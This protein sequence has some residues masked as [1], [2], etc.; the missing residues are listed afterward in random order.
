MYL[1]LANF[2]CTQRSAAL[3]L[4][5]WRRCYE[6]G[7]W[8]SKLIA[9]TVAGRTGFWY[10]GILR[11]PNDMFWIMMTVLEKESAKDLGNLAM[12]LENGVDTGP[13]SGDKKLELNL[14]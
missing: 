13:P 8:N 11:P 3:L 7:S 14:N 12:E 10:S 2:R 5:R 9:K 1:Y 4:R 6:A